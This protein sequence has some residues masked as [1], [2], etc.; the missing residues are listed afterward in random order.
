MLEKLLIVLAVIFIILICIISFF[1]KS[2]VMQ[3]TWEG[4]FRHI[5]AAMIGWLAFSFLFFVTLVI[6]MYESDTFSLTSMLDALNISLMFLLCGF[7][8]LFGFL[9]LFRKPSSKEPRN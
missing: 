7:A 3:T 9:F 8:V 2:G 5:V 1:K 6:A 4:A